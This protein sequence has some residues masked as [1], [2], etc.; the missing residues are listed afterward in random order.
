MRSYRVLGQHRDGFAQLAQ[1]QVGDILAV[2]RDRAAVEL[3]HAEERQHAE[4]NACAVS[5]TAAVCIKTERLRAYSDDLPEPVRPH[6]P[7]F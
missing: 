1:A 4:G 7:T 5:K 3:Q 6:T 2:D